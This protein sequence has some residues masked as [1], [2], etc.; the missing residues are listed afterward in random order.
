PPLCLGAMNF[1]G[2]TD[3]AESEKIILAALDAGLDFIDTADVYTGGESERIV[4]DVLRRSGRR[5][6]VVLATKVGMPSG[7]HPHDRGGSRRHILRSCDESLR[8]LHTDHIELYQ[9]HRPSFDIA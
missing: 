6:E 2:P 8:R 1:G 7:P 4:G 9:L 3:A 5:D